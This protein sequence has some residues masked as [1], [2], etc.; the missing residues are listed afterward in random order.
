MNHMQP[1]QGKY[2]RSLRFIMAFIDVVLSPFV[3]LWYAVIRK[4]K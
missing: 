3:L 2:V 4:A 1:K